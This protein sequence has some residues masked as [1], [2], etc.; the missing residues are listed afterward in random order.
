M[1]TALYFADRIA[2]RILRSG[3]PEANKLGLVEAHAYLTDTYR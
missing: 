3:P 2:R 1:C